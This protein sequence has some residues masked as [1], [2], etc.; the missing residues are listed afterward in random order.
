VNGQMDDHRFED[1]LRSFRPLSPAPLPQRRRQ[2]RLVALGAAAAL[3]IGG[4]LL[5]QFRRVPSGSALPQPITIGSANNLLAN[6]SSW[7][8]AIDD[9]GFAFRSSRANVAP[10]RRSALEFLSQEDLSK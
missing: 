9:A 10:F 7:K 2:W 1:Y 8:E 4:L 3:M 6:S 5:P